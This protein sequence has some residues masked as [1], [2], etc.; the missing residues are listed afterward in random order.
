M[1]P[2]L[3]NLKN[4]RILVV[5]AGKIGTKRVEILLENGGQVFCLGLEFSD[6]I[7]EI[8]NSNLKFIKKKYEPKDLRGMALVV[9]ATNDKQLNARI[10]K[11]AEELGILCNRSD[12][13]EDSD[14]IFPGTL[15]RGELSISVCTEGASPSLTKSILKDLAVQYDESYIERIKRL[16]E[17]RKRILKENKEREILREM[18]YWSLLELREFL[19]TFDNYK[20]ERTGD[21]K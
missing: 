15:R 7:K 6:R 3:F 14:F 2:L 12:A 16:K 4:K 19:E 20:N 18:P 17:C 21:N 8:Q 10:K 11:D 13:P 5:G 9:V 1:L